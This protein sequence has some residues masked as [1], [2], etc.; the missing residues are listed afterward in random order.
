MSEHYL[1][2]PWKRPGSDESPDWSW[3]EDEVSP[4]VDYER[5]RVCAP[6]QRGILEADG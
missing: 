4:P 3:L 6:I 1:T 2:V 5:N